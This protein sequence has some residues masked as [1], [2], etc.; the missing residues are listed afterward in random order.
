MD[1]ADKH[2]HAW[3]RKPFVCQYVFTAFFGKL[4]GEADREQK[5][6]RNLY[7]FW[8]NCVIIFCLVRIRI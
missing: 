1:S 8:D 3:K 7:D 6:F 4:F 2:V 5:V